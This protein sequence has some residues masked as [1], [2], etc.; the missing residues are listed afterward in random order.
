LEWAQPLIRQGARIALPFYEASETALTE[1]FRTA[2]E[3]RY[4]RAPEAFAAYGYDAYRIISA[5]LRQGHQTREALGAALK[6]G[7]GVSSG[8]SIGTLS[9]ERVPAEPPPVYRVVGERLVRAE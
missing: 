4:G 1:R 3:T 2:Y 9:A 7:A 8:T 6:S 5:T